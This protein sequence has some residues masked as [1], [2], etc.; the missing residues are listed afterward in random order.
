MK[1]KLLMSSHEEN[2]QNIIHTKYPENPRWKTSVTVNIIRVDI[3]C[4]YL[5]ISNHESIQSVSPAD[6]LHHYS[7]RLT[8]RWEEDNDET[9]PVIY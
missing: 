2:T 3:I 5:T 1:F 4:L 7:V 8:S 6:F 9:A